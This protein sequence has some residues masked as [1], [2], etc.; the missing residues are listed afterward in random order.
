MT[1]IAMTHLFQEGGGGNAFTGL[2][3]NAFLVV[4]QI[5]NFVLLILFL[6]GLLIK[7][8]MRGLE[9]RRQRI[10]ESLENAHQAD[11]RLA[12]VEHDY[13]ARLA[14]AN[15][16]A[17]KLRADTLQGVHTE[18]EQLRKEAQAEAERI[19]E[20]AHTDALAERNQ[21]LAS[22]RSQVAALAMAAA[23]KIVGESLD[24]QR[25]Q[26]L[27]D[28]FF[29]R[30]PAVLISN[31]GHRAEE[32]LNVAVTSALPLTPVEQ[33]RIECDLDK[34]IGPLR[35]VTYH[36]DPGI[37]GGLVVRVGDKVIDG[38]VAGKLTEMRQALNG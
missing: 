37:L 8:L 4:A 22:L 36:V 16:E 7:P 11:E 9:N 24:A 14:E 28:D 21:M 12:H 2:G 38:S 10:E 30:V 34:Q 23:N 18:L 27:I 15:A 31:N 33:E 3:I 26:A 17:Q 1:F 13:Q 20:Q 19:K 29:A 25:Q 6:N 35:K 32:P 5:L